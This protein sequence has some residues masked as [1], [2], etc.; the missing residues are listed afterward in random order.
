M[1]KEECRGRRLNCTNCDSKHFDQTPA[2]C[3]IVR[4]HTSIRAKKLVPG[5]DN[6]NV[7]TVE[8]NIQNGI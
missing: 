3:A 1:E 7:K 8:T 2:E 5:Y 6:Q 4:D